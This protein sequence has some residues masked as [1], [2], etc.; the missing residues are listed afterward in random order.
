MKNTFLLSL[1]F[2]ASTAAG[3]SCPDFSGKYY[4]GQIFE[5]VQSGCETLTLRLLPNTRPVFELKLD[6]SETPRASTPPW[7]EGAK[8]DGDALV[9]T[10]RYSDEYLS[11]VNIGNAVTTKKVYIFRLSGTGSIL[12]QYQ[13]YGARGQPTESAR[14]YSS[15]FSRISE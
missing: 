15:E 13:T 5:A 1:G 2:L 14:W 8:W 6:G 3:A 7:V 10:S 11:H 9:F 12:F 4:V